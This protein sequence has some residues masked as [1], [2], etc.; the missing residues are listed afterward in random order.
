MATK[1]FFTA[2]EN[3][4]VRRPDGTTYV[5]MEER[6]VY[7]DVKYSWY[8]EPIYYGEDGTT[9]K[10]FQNGDVWR[11]SPDGTL[12]KWFERPT[13]QRAVTDYSNQFYGVFTKFN[14]DGSIYERTPRWRWFWGIKNIKCKPYRIDEDYY[15]D[16]Y[17][18][19]GCHNSY[20]CCG[21]E[22]WQ[23]YSD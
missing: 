4:D 15:E 6:P 8:V 20:S 9:I 17:D 22:P 18:D 11:W 19:C 14:T 2:L 5:S 1:E 12:T 3:V 13:L 7:D 10:W 16:D 21:Y 23:P